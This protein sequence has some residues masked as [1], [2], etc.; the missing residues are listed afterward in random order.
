MVGEAFS[1][2]GVSSAVRIVDSHD[3]RE[4]GEEDGEHT[5]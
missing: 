1:E 4:Q 5:P 3:K 2:G